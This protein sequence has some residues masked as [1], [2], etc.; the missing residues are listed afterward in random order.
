MKKIV[1]IGAGVSGL[2][3]ARLLVDGGNKVTVIEK[4][5]KPG[6]LIKCDNI[7]GCLYHKVGG[8]VFN[9]KRKDVLEWFESIFDKEKDFSKA[10]RNSVV[11]MPDRRLIN[12]PV[13]IYTSFVR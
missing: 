10:D 4:E 7:N 1:V 9:T 8:H 5:N 2:S 3:I 11:S 13:E 12:Y 6:G